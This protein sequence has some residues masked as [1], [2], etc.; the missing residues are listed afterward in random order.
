VRWKYGEKTGKEEDEQ[1]FRNEDMEKKME[2]K[3]KTF[4]NR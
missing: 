3:N 2:E 4:S 1:K